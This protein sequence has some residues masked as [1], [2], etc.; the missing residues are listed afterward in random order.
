MIDMENEN[1]FANWLWVDW[2]SKKI[3][4][5]PIFLL[6]VEKV[7]VLFTRDLVKEGME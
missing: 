5:T 3:R 2:F 1:C 4:M 6:K 7:K